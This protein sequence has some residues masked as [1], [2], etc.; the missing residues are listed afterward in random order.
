MPL[1]GRELEPLTRSANVRR[2][3][4]Q[5]RYAY[6]DPATMA[7]APLR[8]YPSDRTANLGAVAQSVRAADS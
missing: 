5:T 1:G 8:A 2:V 4:L 3:L 7:H 6:R